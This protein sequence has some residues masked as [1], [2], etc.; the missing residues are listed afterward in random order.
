MRDVKTAVAKNIAKY[1]IKSNMTQLELAQ[2]INYSDK[3]VSKWE[4]GE[5]LPD[6]T[7]LCEISDIFGIPIDALVNEES[8]IKPPILKSEHDK[9]RRRI[10]TY[11]VDG[12]IFAVSLLL[13]VLSA[14]LSGQFS[15]YSWLYFLYALPVEL[16]VKLVLNT[17]W[18]DKRKNYLIISLFVWS[19]ITAVYFTFFYFAGKNLYPLFF[20][21]VPAQVI[22]ILWSFIKP[23]PKNS[24][25]R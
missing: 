14:F 17:V 7:A 8:E 25:N 15:N 20:L 3:A 19:V 11:I 1:R 24:E 23:K 22:I 10:I 2:K 18:F 4:R 13:F 21:G 12:F 16:L 6:I 9:R 5:S